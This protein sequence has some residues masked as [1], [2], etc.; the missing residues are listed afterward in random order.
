M[1]INPQFIQS[2]WPLSHVTLGDVAQTYPTRQVVRVRADEG[3]FVAKVDA[4]PPV[5]AS[6]RRMMFIYDFLADRDFPHAP[7][8]LR[9]RNGAPLVYGASQS[10]CLM[11]YIPHGLPG[12]TEPPDPQAQVWQALGQAAA[13]LNA[14]TGYPYAHPITVSGVVA[15]LTAW[16][17]GHSFESHFLAL[18]SRLGALEHS[19][20]I[21]LIHAEI[22]PA[23]ARRRDDGTV[24]LLDWDEAGNGPA[25]LEA[26]Y[27]LITVFLSEVDFTFQRG[28]AAAFY[29][30]YTG[31]AGMSERN[32]QLLFTAALLHALRYMRFANVERRW[33]RICY[34]VA[35]EAMLLD[36]LP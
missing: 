21:G 1:L 11:E 17:K 9:T 20:P 25:M 4:G 5:E 29:R 15:E 18:V 14:I 28:Q 32:R 8:L 31:G 30:G 27:P 23:N 16:V 7:A 24:V 13:A 10:V 19:R 6:A 3:D 22:N 36:V 2:H 34:A 26:G 12:F 35:H 33:E